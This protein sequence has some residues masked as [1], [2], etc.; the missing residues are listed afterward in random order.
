MAK[1]KRS[2]EINVESESESD[3][4]DSDDYDSR[5]NKIDFKKVNEEEELRRAHL[6]FL[7]H[8]LSSN[9]GRFGKDKVRMCDEDRRQLTQLLAYVTDRLEK[10][11]L[12][13]DRNVLGNYM[14]EIQVPVEDC[15][16]RPYSQGLV[17]ECPFLV[18]F[19]LK[20]MLKRTASDEETFTRDEI[21]MISRTF[22]YIKECLDVCEPELGMDFYLSSSIKR[23]KT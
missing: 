22:T 1:S 20:D 12:F 16:G 17:A 13:A 9:N 5:R 14:E 19:F 8:I 3:A 18:D 23:S 6:D 10:I 11:R 21:S 7:R 2:R 4:G 15:V